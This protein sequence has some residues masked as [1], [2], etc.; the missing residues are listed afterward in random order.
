MTGYDFAT[1][2]RIRSLGMPNNSLEPTRE[3]RAKMD[4]GLADVA[5]TRIRGAIADEGAFH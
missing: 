1:A 5:R 2:L 3:R 4:A